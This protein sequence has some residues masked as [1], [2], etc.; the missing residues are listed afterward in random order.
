MK[1][2]VSGSCEAQANNSKN[3][4]CSNGGCVRKKTD[5]SCAGC[6]ILRTWMQNIERGVGMTNSG[7]IKQ[8]FV[9]S[10]WGNHRV[11]AKASGSRNTEAASFGIQE[12][13]RNG[14]YLLRTPPPEWDCFCVTLLKVQISERGASLAYCGSSVPPVAR[15]RGHLDGRSFQE[16][17]GVCTLSSR[18]P[19]K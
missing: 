11:E 16:E 17:G 2:V 14:W 19:S 15:G 5:P 1:V 18:K 6:D 9:V 8:N 12:A 13:E 7:L 10:S 4:N 3:L